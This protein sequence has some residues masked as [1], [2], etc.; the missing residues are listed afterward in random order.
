MSLLD[1]NKNWFLISYYH[2]LDV[3][4]SRPNGFDSDIIKN[5]VHTFHSE[6]LEIFYSYMQTLKHKNLNLV[7]IILT[8]SVSFIP[9]NILNRCMIVPIKRPTKSSYIKV[10]NKSQF[11]NHKLSSIKNIKFKS[12]YTI[13]II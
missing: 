1:A 5:I 12:K 9:N 8:E 3:L 2:I 7:Y 13:L 10:T 6:L 11:N 4:S